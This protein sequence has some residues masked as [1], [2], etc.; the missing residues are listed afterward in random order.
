MNES[1][2]MRLFLSLVKGIIDN[3][4]EHLDDYL[5][6]DAIDWER[7]K[8][9][10]VFHELFPFFYKKLKDNITF[11]PAD[12]LVFLKSGHYYTLIRSEQL[13]RQFQTLAEVFQEKNLSMVPIKGMA[14]LAD[15]YREM[16]FRAMVDIDILVREEEMKGV[17]E[18]LAELGYASS[19]CGLKEAYWLGQHCELAFVKD[20]KAP[21]DVH[22][23]LDFKRPGTS[24]LPHL[25]ER[26]Q[27]VSVENQ[28]ISLLSPEDQLFSLALHGRRYGGKMFCLK[29]VLDLAMILKKY[30]NGFDWDYVLRE[31]RTGKMRSTVFFTLLQAKTFFDAAVPEFLWKQLR[32]SEGKNKAITRLIKDNTFAPLPADKGRELFLKS[33]FLLFDDPWEPIRYILAIPI[34]QFAKYYGME[35]Y[36]KITKLLYYLRF[37]YLPYRYI[38]GKMS[39]GG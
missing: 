9:I 3:E 18:A 30:G 11:I 25:W 7:F 15:I 24:V 34:E 32:I 5:P 33:H 38:R 13:W 17:K 26:V 28:K 8:D 19:L 6:K 35:P 37:I 23:R 16:P 29:N 22:F 27:K 12:F 10:V 1:R 20:G 14:G 21:V 2:E 31:A 36:A 39:R 4:I